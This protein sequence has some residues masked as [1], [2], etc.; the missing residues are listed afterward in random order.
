M[1]ATPLGSP[2]DPD[3]KPPD[4]RVPPPMLRFFDRAALVG[5]PEDAVARLRG[6]VE[7]G[8]RYFVPAGIGPDAETV[9]LLV[10]R[11]IPAVVA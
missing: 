7:S 8:F 5:T 2:L 11:V 10:R 6:L 3:V 1:T 4:Y 9:D